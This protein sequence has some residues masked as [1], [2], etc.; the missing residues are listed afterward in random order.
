V[1]EERH[2]G[3]EVTERVGRDQVAIRVEHYGQG[4]EAE[5]EVDQR[6]GIEVPVEVLDAEGRKD[7]V[8]DP[9]RRSEDEADDEVGGRA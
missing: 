9:D 7:E 8:V 6:A 3:V 2:A 5:H 4:D 1:Q